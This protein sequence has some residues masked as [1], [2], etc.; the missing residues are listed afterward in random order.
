[1]SDPNRARWRRA[2]S[3][4]G[5]LLVALT[6]SVS[7]TTVVAKNFAALC[8]EADMIFTATVG[9]VRSQRV[10]DAH[11]NLETWVT[12]TAID[13]VFGVSSPT[14][15]LRFAGGVV[16][17]VREEFLG[18]PRFTTGERV[19]LFARHGYQMSP[20][21]GMSQGCFRVVDSPSGVTLTSADGQPVLALDSGVIPSDGGQAAGGAPL[22]LSRFLDEVRNELQAQGRRD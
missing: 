19:V 12:F 20:I 1:M 11:G 16:D 14:I 5:L 7:A 22:S 10:D 3:L 18:V 2:V 9:D 17:G 21:V 13:P 6:A 15:T 4:A 8:A